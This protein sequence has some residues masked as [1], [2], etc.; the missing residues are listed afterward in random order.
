MT[1]S[2][3]RATER[4]Q[5]GKKS[6]LAGKTPKSPGPASPSSAGPTFWLPPSATLAAR[7][8][9]R[10]RMGRISAGMYS[11]TSSSATGVRLAKGRRA[12]VGD[13]TSQRGAYSL[14]RGRGARERGSGSRIYN[15][16]PKVPRLEIIQ[17]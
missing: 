11:L 10:R 14:A 2:A 3:E 15:P 12:S 17:R 16:T 4:N 13:A 7:Q 6:S 5:V 1:G 8:R 9:R